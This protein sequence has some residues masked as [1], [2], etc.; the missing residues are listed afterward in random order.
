MKKTS[1]TEKWKNR[2]KN[3]KLTFFKRLFFQKRHFENILSVH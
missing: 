3:T 1:K 2:R